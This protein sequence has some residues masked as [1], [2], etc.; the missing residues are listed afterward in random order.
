MQ[1]G[2]FT[3]RNFLKISIISLYCSF[4]RIPT[5]QTIQ[6]SKWGFMTI[7]FR[8]Y[9]NQPVTFDHRRIWPQK[10]NQKGELKVESLKE[11]PKSQN[12]KVRENLLVDMQ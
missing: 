1:I 5:F 2:Y 6:H 9:Y 7:F 10:E 4:G 8:K 12:L 11:N 3:Q